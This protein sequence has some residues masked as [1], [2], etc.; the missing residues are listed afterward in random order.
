MKKRDFRS[1]FA[2]LLKTDYKNETLVTFVTE[3]LDTFGILDAKFEA[4]Y[5][6]M[7]KLPGAK[8]FTIVQ[9][10]N[11]QLSFIDQIPLFDGAEENDTEEVFVVERYTNY[12]LLE[13]TVVPTSRLDQQLNNLSNDLKPVEDAESI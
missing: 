7:N 13:K 12:V 4:L 11:F 6:K 2:D 1:E 5:A 3:L 9:Q 8:D 10:P